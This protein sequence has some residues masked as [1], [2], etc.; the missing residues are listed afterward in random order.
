MGSKG[1]ALVR[2]IHAIMFFRISK[3]FTINEK[4]SIGFLDCKLAFGKSFN[5]SCKILDEN[6]SLAINSAAFEKL[7]NALP[8]TDICS[9]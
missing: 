3:R 9:K 6:S 5:A 7:C 2:K 8:V 1:L 4:S